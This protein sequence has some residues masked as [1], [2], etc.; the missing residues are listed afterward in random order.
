MGFASISSMARCRRRVSRRRAILR[1]FQPC[2]VALLLVK[3]YQTERA[4]AWVAQVLAPDGLAVTFQNGLDNGPKLEASIGIAHAALGVNYT[5]ATLVGPGET[6]HT[7][8][9]TN[10]IGTR[11]APSRRKPL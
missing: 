4:A 10:L 3:S 2:D 7:A 1:R 5:G 8:Q 6:R 11:P 9:L